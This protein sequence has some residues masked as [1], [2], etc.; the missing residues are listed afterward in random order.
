[1][2]DFCSQKRS[3]RDILRDENSAESLDIDDDVAKEGHDIGDDE[4]LCIDC[5]DQPA[6]IS[7]LNCEEDF[8]DVCFNYI[9]RTGR[10]KMHEKKRIKVHDDEDVKN[11][12][13]E[14]GTNEAV[15]QEHKDAY[16]EL[17]ASDDEELIPGLIVSG[18][19]AS[20]GTWLRKR[21]QYIPL[22][23]SAE[24]RQF[25]RLLDAALNVSEYT[26]RVDIISYGSRAKRIVSQL[27][28]M[29][30]IL[31]GLYVARD[32]KAASTLFNDTEELAENAE[33]FKMIFEIGRR[34]KIL[35][36]D[37]L[38]GSYGK[39]VYMVMVSIALIHLLTLGL[40]YSRS[41]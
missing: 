29:C 19:S 12:T 34:Y 39:L 32:F 6:S 31:A 25:L 38:K 22:R 40:D 21:C 35:N 17:S 24:E 36:P 4:G 1:M 11:G 23:L 9:H 26:D 13:D 10:R 30:A 16:D 37:K 15:D 5:G 14:N 27:K 3:L 2:A 20:F 8:C 18:G 7:C 41:C 28:E 33:W